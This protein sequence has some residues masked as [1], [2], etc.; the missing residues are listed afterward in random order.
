MTE[1]PS[2]TETAEDE[3]QRTLT[4]EAQRALAEAEARRKA[5]REAEA[6]L[7]K[8]IGGGGGKEPGRYGDWEVKGLTSDF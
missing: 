5:Y 1:Q 2:K 8:E 3:P 6:R 7:P 4:P